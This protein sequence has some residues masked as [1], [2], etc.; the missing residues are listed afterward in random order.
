MNLGGEQ[1]GHIITLDY[2]TT[3]DGIL[4]ALLTVAK[5]VL[6]KKPLSSFQ[7]LMNRYPQVLVNVVVKEKRPLESVPALSAAISGAEKKVGKKGRVLFRYSGTE[8]KARIMVEA[9]S[10]S[11]CKD[12]AS[13]IEGVVRK[14]LCF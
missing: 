5:V 10:D 1:S 3:G 7:G 11:L 2:N 6:S 13:E 14:E 12:I 4:T 8:Q 9:E